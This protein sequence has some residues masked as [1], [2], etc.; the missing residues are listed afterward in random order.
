MQ[1]RCCNYGHSLLDKR[2]YL[3]TGLTRRE[4]RPGSI[5]GGQTPVA[6]RGRARP[7]PM[8]SSGLCWGLLPC[9][10]RRLHED[11]HQ[12]LDQTC[13]CSRKGASKFL[14]VLQK[15]KSKPGCMNFDMY[16]GT[17]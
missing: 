1:V 12:L 3:V 15:K 17:T 5:L 2:P 7:D 6:I 13:L 11:H 4:V 8:A 9:G 10:G 16:F 14:P